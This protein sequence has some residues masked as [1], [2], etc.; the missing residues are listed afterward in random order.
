MPSIISNK[1]CWSKYISLS[2]GYQDVFLKY[3]DSQLF[4]LLLDSCFISTEENVLKNPASYVKVISDFLTGNKVYKG[5]AN[6]IRYCS[7]CISEAIEIYG[8]AYFSAHWTSPGSGNNCK[9]HEVP[10]YVIDSYCKKDTLYA[11][12]IVMMGKKSEFCKSL[13]NSDFCPEGEYYFSLLEGPEKKPPHL[14]PCLINKLKAWLILDG[15]TFPTELITA[16]R[17][18][19]HSSLVSSMETYVFK[20][21]LLKRAYVTL[22]NSNYKIFHD[23]LTKNSE[24]HTFYCGIIE[25]QGLKGVIARLQG[26]NCSKCSD[27]HCPAN[28]SIIHPSGMP[29]S[30][31]G[32]RCPLT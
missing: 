10:L 20:N 1:G 12:D 32:H 21:Y 25:K 4:N 16:V 30:F 3:T 7:K 24:L 5:H 9:I 27:V 29:S 19:S 14:A 26:S 8:F 17:C 6:R 15:H 11:L 31:N 22:Y 18:A 2:H 13:N 23:F 28:H